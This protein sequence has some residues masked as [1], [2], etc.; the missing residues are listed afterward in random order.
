MS[1]AV[2]SGDSALDAVAL[3]RSSVVDSWFLKSNA[4]GE[5]ADASGWGIFLSAAVES[6]D[7]RSMVVE[8]TLSGLVTNTGISGSAK[9]RKQNEN[10]KK[11]HSAEAE[12]AQLVSNAGCSTCKAQSTQDAGRDAM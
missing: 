2:D 7:L 3:V 5:T 10:A 4:V 9:Q 12:E 8:Q 1:N 11:T 6:G